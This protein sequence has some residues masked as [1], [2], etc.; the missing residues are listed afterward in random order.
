[1][2]QSLSLRLVA[3]RLLTNNGPNGNICT[4]SVRDHLF[5]RPTLAGTGVRTD[6]YRRVHAAVDIALFAF[7]C[8]MSV[9]SGSPDSTPKEVNGMAESG[10]SPRVA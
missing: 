8:R 9:Y 5:S 3:M 6:F 10:E 7:G 1:V 2:E 4:G